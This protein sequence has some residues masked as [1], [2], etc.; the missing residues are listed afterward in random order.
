MGTGCAAEGFK[1]DEL[2]LRLTVEEVLRE[3]LGRPVTLGA[4]KREPS[5]FATL[6]PAEV[7]SMELE[8]NHKL[9]L[10]LKH[11][12]CEDVDY[13]EKPCGNREIQIYEELLNDGELPV[14]KYYGSRWNETTGRQELFLEYINDWNLKYQDLEHWFTAARR[15]AKFHAHFAARAEN[16][17]AAEFL[18]RFDATY[19][20]Q[21]AARALSA[22]A[23]YD[24]ELAGRVA[25]VV[26]DYERATE[27]L[28]RQPLTLVHNDLAPKNVI[29]DRSTNPARICFVD[30]A[31]A[32]VGCGL[33][34]LA[35]L[36]YGLDP[37]ND[38]EMCVAYSRELAGTGLLPSSPKELSSLLAACEL[39]RMLY[40]LAFSKTWQLPIETVSEWVT[41]SQQLLAR[42]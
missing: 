37:A 23:E 17:L 19:L 42:V 30:W 26:H 7:L 28:V 25:D 6:V 14:V 34:D 5:P 41:D 4:F 27:L 11:V 29:A 15:L 22:V 39:Q 20:E 36:K 16:L 40:R 21:W 1:P 33:L 32:G 18:P 13:R 38:L 3:T 2:R 10:F 9:S 12:A 31:D 35:H 24:A 8:D